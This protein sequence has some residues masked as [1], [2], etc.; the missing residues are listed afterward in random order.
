VVKVRPWIPGLA[1]AALTATA[2]CTS[3]LG[4]KNPSLRWCAQQNPQHDFCEDFDHE[5]AIDSWTLKPTPTGGAGRSIIASDDSPP[6]ALSTSVPPQPTGQGNLTGLANAFPDRSI[7]HVIIELDIRIDKAEFMQDG[8][9]VSGIG[10]L[11]LEDTSKLSNT[12]NTCMGLVLAPPS[13]GLSG[14]IAVAAVVI[15]AADCFSVNNLMDAAASDAGGGG[16]TMDSGAPPQPIVIATILTNQWQHVKLELIRGEDGSGIL[17]PT[18]NTTGAIPAVPVPAELF[19]PGYPQLGIASSVTG[20]AGN[21][22]ID[23]DNVTADFP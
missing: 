2:A 23:F 20:P 4:L 22:E 11:L 21:V 3:V 18:L 1:F 19:P 14:T 7:D 13:S 10:F 16:A 17:Q 15:P 5:N 8:P 6:N 12:L 9:I